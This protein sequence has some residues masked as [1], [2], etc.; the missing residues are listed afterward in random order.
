MLRPPMPGTGASGSPL[1]RHRAAGGTVPN[2]SITGSASS[3][4]GANS[5]SPSA[6]SP[7]WAPVTTTSGRPRIGSGTNG[8]GGGVRKRTLDVSSAG[9][10]R[11]QS[12]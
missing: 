6:G 2:M 10:W 5:F 3:R 7:A 1:I 8:I 12:R 11:A 4:I 9:A